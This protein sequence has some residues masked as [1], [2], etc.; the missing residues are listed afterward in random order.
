MDSTHQNCCLPHLKVFLVDDHAPIRGRIAGLLKAMKGVTLV[1]E[2]E[3]PASATSGIR[4]SEP[5]AVL[6]DFQLIGGTGL[7]VLKAVHADYPAIVFIV[8]T[9][10]ANP[11]YRQ[12]CLASGASHFLDKSHDFHRVEEIL[13]DLH[14]SKTRH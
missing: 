14:A 13:V 4:E 5:D 9:N 8:M 10:H 11:Q 6:L 2:A 1:G 12:L 7:E 3:T